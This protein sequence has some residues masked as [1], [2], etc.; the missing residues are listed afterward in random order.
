MIVRLIK[1][2]KIYNFTLPTKIAGNY[3]ITDND[4]LGN[5]RNLINVEEFDGHWK[6]K[7]DFET[8][9]MLGENEI[10][11]AILS[12]Y[13][14]FFLK[15]NTDNEYVIL[16]C[17]PSIEP[18]INR[19]HV[20]GDCEI[21]IGNDPSSTICYNYPLISRQQ[22]RLVYNKGIWVIQDLNSKYGTYANNVAIASKQLEYGDII[23]IMGLKI[24]VLKDSIIINRI[25]NIVNYDQR[26]LEEEHPWI[27][28]QT[29]MDNPDEENIEFYKEDDYFY[30]APRFK[31]KIEPINVN[32]DTPPGKQQE[33]KTPLIYTVGPML[34]MSMMSATTGITALQ[35]LADG[36]KDFKTAAPS[37]ITT[38]V[39]LSTMILWPSLTKIYQTKQNRK[40]EE[41]RQAMYKKYVDSKRTEIQNAM[42]VQRQILVDNYL[43]IQETKEIIFGKKRNLWER[44]IDQPDFLDLRLGIGTTE[45]AG[46][47]NFP[48]EHFSIDSDN[49]LQEVYKLGAESRLL[50][51]VP[52]STSFVEKNITAIIGTAENK[53]QFI[54]GLILQMIAYHSYEDLK[55][56]LMTN[57]KNSS[58]WEYLKICPHCWSNDR[59]IRY[60]ANTLDE[61]KEI[62]LALEQELQARKYKDVN[63]GYTR[64]IKTGP[65]RGDAAEMCIIE[66]V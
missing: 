39:M 62:S 17:S 43:P 45:L 14:L 48:Q 24:I 44:E 18:N 2:T 53:Q 58:K 21:T 52:I 33:D 30:R 32:I 41:T 35:G 46:S 1:K 50:E 38:G 13:S 31:T 27:Q 20:R 57:E 12:E 54:E 55:I 37:L 36:S 7:S 63:G 51:N 8:K 42:K 23:F 19:L 65:R 3:W 29:E 9:I 60:F 15:I 49:L 47:I 16:Y 66:L 5:T 34:T 6:I 28:N 4:Y 64:I 26:V 10:E 11:S 61:A 56:V 22:A 25:S 40:K 59:S